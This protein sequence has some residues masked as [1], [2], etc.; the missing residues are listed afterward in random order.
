MPHSGRRDERGQALSTFVGVVV[1]ALFLVTGLVVDGGAKAAIT[2]EAEAV[3]AHAAR[4][5]ADAGGVSRA[6]GAPLD[7]SAVRSAA[8]AVLEDRGV[9]GIVAVE[10]SGVRVTTRTSTRT[11]FLSVLGI[12]ELAASGEATASLE[13]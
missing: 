3:A 7:L 9:Q 12:N 13:R 11:V 5:G 2:R 4:A 10:A 8:Q 1:A 6:A